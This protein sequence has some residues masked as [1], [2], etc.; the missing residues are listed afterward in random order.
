MA[1]I[2]APVLA[3]NGGEVSKVALGRVDVEKMRVTAQCQV[4]WL[5]FVVGPA[6]LRPGLEHIG[7]IYEDMV[8]KSIPFV[9]AR[10][11]TAAIELTHE[12][13][14]VWVA[15]ELVTRLPI[16]TVVQN[17]DFAAS[18][19]WTL[20]ASSGCTVA[21]TGNE[22]ILAP[23]ARGG[24][25]TATQLVAVGSGDFNREHALDIV[26]SHGPVTFSIGTASGTDDLVG[27]SSLDTGYHSL[28]FTPSGDFYIQFEALGGS[29]D[30]SGLFG[31]RVGYCSITAPGVMS[32][33]TPWTADDLSLLRWT[34]SGDV[35]YIACEG[36]QQRKIER[37]AAHSWSVVTYQSDDGPFADVPA[38]NLLMGPSDVYGNAQIG[39][40]KSFFKPGHVGCLIRLFSAG[41]NLKTTLGGPESCTD[42]VRISGVSADRTFTWTL[43]GTY[44]GTLK[45][46]RS[47]DGPDSGFIDVSETSGAGGELAD[48]LDNVIC[49]YRIAFTS[50][51]SGAVTIAFAYTGGG[52]Y[53]VARITGFVAPTVVAV[54][55]LQPFASAQG[56]DSWVLSEWSD[57]AGWPT[58]V[59]FGEGRLGWWGIDRTWLSHSGRYQSYAQQDRFGNALGDAGAIIEVF[60]DGP[61]GRVSWALSLSRLLCGLETAIKSI[62]SSSFDE[63]LTAT[64]YSVKDCSTQGA[65]RLPAVKIDQR[66]VFVSGRRVYALDFSSKALDYAASD[67]TRLN[68]D[69]GKPGFTAT[70]VARQPDTMIHLPRTEGQVACFLDDVNDEVACWWRVMTLGIVE[71]VMVLPAADVLQD[72]VYYTVRRYVNGTWRRFREKLAPRDNC[73]GGALNQL[74]DC[75]TVYQGAAAATMTVAH[76]PNTTVMVWADGT[77]RGTALTDGA[78]LFTV[79][80]AAA[81]T[82]V[83]GLGGEMKTQTSADPATAF[84]GLSA[85]E[86][87]PA[88]VFADNQPSDRLIHMG[89]LTVTDG[90]LVLPNG[91]TASTIIA[92]FG[93][94]APLMS[95]KLAYA[96][97]GG[98]AVTQKK[99]INHLGLLLFNTHARGIQFGQDFSKL[100]SLPEYERGGEVDPDKIWSEYDEPGI[101]VPG[102][103]DTDARLCLL[104]MAP[105]PATV[106]GLVI[107]LTTNG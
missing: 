40:N 8:S 42:A 35:I 93:F 14:R 78:G 10:D 23:I 56:T 104:A 86:G 107:D 49:W 29:K 47:Y 80:G 73:I 3:L 9:F 31:R 34:G 28:A 53:G 59:A 18:T 82:I 100:D 79:P 41:Q 81:A 88:E 84:T 60:G 64:N 96:A 37:R 63:P 89:T 39:C 24:A 65:S 11:D 19:G 94:A 76:L 12:R 58:A 90:Q 21:I 67:L 25:T 30:G 61:I 17:G 55:I 54:E 33:A 6:M 26:V 20:A 98:T 38:A 105:Y 51:T 16:S 69:I 48:T 85:Y 70:G 1:R 71:D 2:N 83:A 32:V 27:T 106:G 62:R 66:G 75:H 7:S 46:Q 72:D 91:Q 15:D 77:Y 22:L 74:L 36:K 4:N 52:G 87:L 50:Y 13:M 68:I 92:F 43:T 44:V 97:Q 103:W 99:K 5:P 57:E 95:T 101:E 102:T 45:L